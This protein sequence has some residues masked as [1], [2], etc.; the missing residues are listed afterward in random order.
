MPFWQPIK[1]AVDKQAILLNLTV[2]D[3]QDSFIA[4]ISA[5]N[6]ESML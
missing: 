1:I 5:Q 3:K 2:S 4:L 6:S